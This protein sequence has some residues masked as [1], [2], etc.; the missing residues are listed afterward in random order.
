MYLAASVV[1]LGRIDNITEKTMKS[2]VVKT[3]SD[4]RSRFRKTSEQQTRGFVA[5]IHTCI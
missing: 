2:K 1:Q 3:V 5:Y 4:V